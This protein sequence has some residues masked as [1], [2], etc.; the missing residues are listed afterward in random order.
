MT[1]LPI[2]QRELRVATRRKSTYRIRFWTVV[3]AMAVASLMLL[4]GSLAGASGDFAFHILA[5]YSFALA[6]SSGIFMTA[7]A[8]SEEK[9]EGTLGL[10]FLT[11][12]TGYD[13]VLGKFASLALNPLYCLVGTFPLLALPVLLGGV[14]GDEFQRMC[15]ALLNGLFFSLALGLLLSAVSS[16]GRRALG[17]T[18]LVLLLL[19]AAAIVRFAVGRPGRGLDFLLCLNPVVSFATAFESRYLTDAPSYRLSLAGSHLIGWFLLAFASWFL[20][21]HWQDQPVS[22]PRSRSWLRRP[23]GPRLLDTPPVAWLL[24]RWEQWHF[25]A[26]ALGLGSVA[27]GIIVGMQS[28]AGAAFMALYAVLF[29]FKILVAL[30]AC[31]FFSEARR[32]GAIELLVCTPLSER[33]IISGQWLALRRVFRWPWILL[34]F[35]CLAPLY[36]N[37][38]QGQLHGR[39]AGLGS[40][41]LAATLIYPYARFVLDVLAIGWFGMLMALTMKRPAL[42]AAVTIAVIVVAPSLLF[43]I[44]NIVIDVVFIAIARAKLDG[45]VRRILAAR[46]VQSAPPAPR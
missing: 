42:S 14:T 34:F 19:V 1:F 45:S 4:F 10:L 29:L 5:F 15:L 40:F 27:T 8:L 22:G 25:L 37:Y 41:F 21:R 16:D 39:S 18:L 31:A 24:Q 36:V 11:D 17:R 43:C 26:W 38:V 12:L 44:P 2:V 20:P 7:D 9:R 3:I 33:D 13:V 6:L 32:S 35:G 28:A 23:R 46:W 30:Q